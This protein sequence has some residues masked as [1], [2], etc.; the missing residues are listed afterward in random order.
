MALSHRIIPPEN[1]EPIIRI[2]DLLSESLNALVAT[3]ALQHA[4]LMSL[5]QLLNPPGEHGSVHAPI[6]DEEI[7]QE[8][9]KFEDVEGFAEV[10]DDDEPIEVARPTRREA[11]NAMAILQNFAITM[12]DPIARKL[13]GILGSFGRQ[14]RLKES[15]DLVNTTITQ[16]FARK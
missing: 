9:L 8:V 6:T 13:E 16:Y 15:K 4:N 10:S 5:E 12:E 1:A 7:Y 2:E 11:L 14:M 3:G